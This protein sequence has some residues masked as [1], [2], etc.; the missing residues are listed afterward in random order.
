[1]SATADVVALPAYPPQRAVHPV[2]AIAT[3]EL[4]D[5]WSDLR[6][7]TLAVLCLVLALAALLQ[8]AVSAQRQHQHLHAAEQSD[9][10]VWTAQGDKNPHAAAHF[11]QYAFKPVG[12]L[13]LAD[14][15]IDTHAGRAVWLEAHKQ[16]DMQFR[17]AR[18]AD[19][20]ERMGRLSLAFVW[21]AVLPLLALMLGH[22]AIGV[23]RTQGTLRP[24]LALGVRPWQLVVGKALAQS[25]VTGSLLALTCLALAGMA[26]AVDG[27]HGPVGAVSDGIWRVLGMAFA[28]LP[29]LLGFVLLGVAVAAAV[30][31]D[32][33]A[34]LGLVAFWLVNTFVAPRVASDWV[35]RQ[36]PLPTA[37]AFR[38]AMAADKKQQFG[39]DEKHP[40]FQAFRQRVLSQYK[41]QRV[42]DLP[43]S[44]RGLALREDDEAGYRI[45]DKH[46]GQLQARLDAQDQLRAQMG[47]VFPQL[48]LQPLSMAMAGTDNRHHH[49]FVQAAEA[50][51]RVIQTAASGD[52]IRNARNGDAGYTAKAELWSQIPA[53]QYQQPQ[54]AWALQ[55]LG[56]NLLMLWSWCLACALAAVV[57]AQRRLMK[58]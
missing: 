37:Q 42:E 34:L 35:D 7:R 38:E 31:N 53:L 48:A 13:A 51:R 22:A 40:G 12:A 8:G 55:G 14:P 24:L 33:V 39:H 45:Y 50:H 47:W 28:Y 17:P 46:Y 11:G 44:F 6:W 30:P 2:W 25:I 16:N 52:L 18:D 4:R 32:R 54:A 58:A 20:A 3:K 5:L 56:V 43:V 9:R 1:M 10:R 49:H 15:G 21:Q 26:L 57:A 36:L 29:Y 41:V 23:E 27:S 19:L